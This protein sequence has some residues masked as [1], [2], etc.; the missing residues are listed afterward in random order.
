MI[1]NESCNIGAK[2]RSPSGLVEAKTSVCSK[3][4]N[5]AILVANYVAGIRESRNKSPGSFK[6]IPVSLTPIEKIS[7]DYPKGAIIDLDRDKRDA[8][9]EEY[10]DSDEE[11][12]NLRS[13]KSDKKGK[14]EQKEKKD[15]KNKKEKKDK[16]EKKDKK[17]PIKSGK[18]P[19]KAKE[20][21]AENK[22]AKSKYGHLNVTGMNGLN[23]EEEMDSNEEDETDEW[24]ESYDGDDYLINY[25]RDWMFCEQFRVPAMVD[26]NDVKKWN[27]TIA[28]ILVQRK[29][30]IEGVYDVTDDIPVQGR[31]LIVAG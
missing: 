15:K 16:E 9:D 6:S 23:L 24:E 21:A 3:D 22:P 2:Y 17:K 1:S 20:S 19:S 4:K 5:N 28:S 13:T 26:T 27:Q 29:R 18:K 12:N 25:E 7:K 30:L 14:K 10:D 31:L 11:E 8:S